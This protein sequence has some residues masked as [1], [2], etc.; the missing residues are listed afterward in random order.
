MEIKIH[1][2]VGLNEGLYEGGGKYPINSDSFL[3]YCFPLFNDRILHIG[4]KDYY[5][6]TEFA[7]LRQHFLDLPFQEKLELTSDSQ[8]YISPSVFS[9]LGQRAT[10]IA[11]NKKVKRKHKISSSLIDIYVEHNSVWSAEDELDAIFTRF[12][13]EFQKT[14]IQK[15]NRNDFPIKSYSMYEPQ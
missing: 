9:N 15:F 4:C 6:G 7:H 14:M 10:L 1:S 3:G 12:D 2:F 5:H 13:T 11:L 8:D